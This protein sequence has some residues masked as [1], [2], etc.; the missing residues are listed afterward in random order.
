M[1]ARMA[2]LLRRAPYRQFLTDAWKEKMQRISD[3]SGCRSC[4]AKCPYG[5]D[6]PVLLKTMLADY[7]QFAREH[8]A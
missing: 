6:T 8:A 5:L 2:F 7:E 3:C 1:A 4:V